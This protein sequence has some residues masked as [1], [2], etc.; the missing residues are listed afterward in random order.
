MV[1]SKSFLSFT[2]DESI[3][4][5]FLK[6]NKNIDNNLFKVLYELNNDK[7]IEYDLSTYIDI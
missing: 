4:V 3:A 7:N 1:Y 6:I 2:K 5:K